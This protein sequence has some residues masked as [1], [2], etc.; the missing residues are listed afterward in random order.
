M[1]DNS[2]KVWI[3]V[4]ADEGGDTFD[5]DLAWYKVW[6]QVEAD[7]GGDT[8]DISSYCFECDGDAVAAA[9]ALDDLPEAVRSLLVELE[10]IHNGQGSYIG[11]LDGPALVAVRSLLN[12]LPDRKEVTS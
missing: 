12:D 8:F 9:N 4:E 10:A 3:Q 6:I 2:Y 1:T 11:R 7:E 5:I